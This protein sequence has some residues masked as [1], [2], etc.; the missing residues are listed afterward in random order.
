M[1]EE[2]PSGEEV[3]V[4]RGISAQPFGPLT[5]QREDGQLVNFRENSDGEITHMFVRQRV[6]ERLRD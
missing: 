5:F 3:L 2:L 1:I 6:Y 4:F